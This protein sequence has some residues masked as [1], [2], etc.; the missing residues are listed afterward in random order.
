MLCFT[1]QPKKVV[2]RI[3]NGSP[4]HYADSVCVFILLEIIWVKNIRAYF[5]YF[6]TIMHT[7]IDIMQ[8][9]F[10]NRRKTSLFHA[11]IPYVL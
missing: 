5:H 10:S 7:D 1:S 3:D 4:C 11:L 8:P 9:R 2:T 6:S